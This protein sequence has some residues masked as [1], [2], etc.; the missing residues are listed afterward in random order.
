MLFLK[1]NTKDGVWAIWKIEESK[2]EL[3]SFLDNKTLLE[4]D[5]LSLKSESKVV[6]RLAVRVLLKHLLGKETEICYYTSG[7]PFLQNENFHLSISHTHGYVAVILG[8]RD[9]IAIDI[10][11][12]TEKARSV[13]SKFVSEEEYI[14]PQNELIHLLLH[15]S[16]KESLYKAIGKPGIDL[17]KELYIYPFMPDK[18]GQFDAIVKLDPFNQQFTISYIATPEFVLTYI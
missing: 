2:D 5:V 15:W 11:Y 9:E 8:K 14:D 3:L 18:Y 6:E 16:A 13:R 17:R 1:K 12:I 7:K 4:K 10:Q